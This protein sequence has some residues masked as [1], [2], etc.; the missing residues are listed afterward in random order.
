MTDF[1]SDLLTPH[2]FSVQ[3][4]SGTRAKISLEPLERGFGHTLGNALRRVLLSS[5][6]GSAVCEVKIE[7]VLHEYSSI[8]GCQQDA[9]EILLNLKELAVRSDTG[10]IAQ[11]K[12]K[13]K[14]PKEV[15]AADIELPK[16][17]QIVNTNHVICNLNKGGKIEMEIRVEQGRGYRTADQQTDVDDAE[18]VAVGVLKLDVTFSP[19]VRVS[20]LV[21]H[22]RVERRTDLDKLVLDLETNGTLDP[23][24]AVRHATS[25]LQ[26]QLMAV[27]G[28][29]IPQSSVHAD[30]DQVDPILMRSVDELEL[31][32]RAANCLKA[33]N[34][35]LIGDLVQRTEAELLK[36]PNFGKKSLGEILRVLEERKLT[37]GSNLK[38]WPPTNTPM[39]ADYKS[40]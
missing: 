38:N 22:T 4:I 37:L 26:H 28:I 8:E 15:T 10:E 32:V 24:Y 23:E 35:F 34:I 14:G 18:S 21:E 29:E 39:V 5:M 1:S 3:T 33:E 17:V 2:P 30:E 31:T 9:M 16:D 40:V 12:L 27:S 11:L 20:Y 19:V 25:I 13:A 7:G 6:T 36:T